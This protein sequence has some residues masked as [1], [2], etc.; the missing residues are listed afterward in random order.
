MKKQG[1]R[2]GLVITWSVKSGMTVGKWMHTRTQP[3]LPKVRVLWLNINS[4]GRMAKQAARCG[5]KNRW[6]NP[7]GF[8]SPYAH[9]IMINERKIL[10]MYKKETIKGYEDYSID[11]NGVVYSKKDKPLKYSIN[12]KGYQIVGLSTNHQRKSVGIHTLVAK[13]FISNDNPNKT[14]VNHKDG[15]KQNNNID[16]LE[17]VTPAENMRH[18]VDVLGV[19]IEEN[20]PN[21]KSIMGI[22]NNGETLEFNSLIQGARYFNKNNQYNERCIQNSLWRA[23]QGMRKSYKGYSWKYIN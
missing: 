5:L 3:L 18:A 9:Q 21:A 4:Y 12:H 11:T 16:N 8:E 20:N 2:S 7:W 22:N 6:R 15:N 13:Q 19:H 1:K 17:W 23:L 14:Q 10:K